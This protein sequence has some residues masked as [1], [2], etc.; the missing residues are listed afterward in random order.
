MQHLP[1]QANLQKNI[2]FQFYQSGHMVYAHEASLREIHD[3]LAAF[4]R[5]T[6]GG[7]GK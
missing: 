6:E 2:E 1:I 7:K 3:K 5:S 4:I